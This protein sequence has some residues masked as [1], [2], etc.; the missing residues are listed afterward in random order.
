MNGRPTTLLRWMGI[1]RRPDRLTRFLVGDLSDHERDTL[2]QEFFANPAVFDRLLEAEATLVDDYARGQL[3][4]ALRR[5]FEAHYLA[6]PRLRHRAE[7]ARLLTRAADRAASDPQS[8]PAGTHATPVWLAPLAA[9][10]AVVLVVVSGWLWTQNRRLRAELARAD[11]VRALDDVRYRDLQAE[12][13]RSKEA[14]ARADRPGGQALP[15]AAAPPAA[16]A[17]SVLSLL[18]V[19]PGVRAADTGVRTLVIPPATARVRL[20]IALSERAYPAYR[21]AVRTAAGVEA[22][23]SDS[24]SPTGEGPQTR[25]AA[26]VAAERL[27]AGDYVLTLSGIEMGG[28]PEDVARFL[29]R[30]VRR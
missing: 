24:L 29:V 10:A 1:T 12:L 19:A 26:V 3:P 6:H 8:T 23:A 4:A 27:Q 22:F 25:V 15:P 14:S 21:L 5:Q 9:A 11:S 17:G 16:D 2:E 18:L 7:F 13:A 20:Q 28:Q 30:V